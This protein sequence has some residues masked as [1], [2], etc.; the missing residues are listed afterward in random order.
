MTSLFVTI[1]IQ[2][3]AL[4]NIQRMQY[5]KTSVSAEAAKLIANMDIIEGNFAKVWTILTDRYDNK[6]AMRDAHLETLFELPDMTFESAHELRDLYDK[7]KECIQLLQG[8][9]V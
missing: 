4:D 6:R 1:V 5:L 7:S 8:V 2:N 3:G 9:S